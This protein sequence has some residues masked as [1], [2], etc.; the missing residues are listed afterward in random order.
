[1]MPNPRKADALDELVQKFVRNDPKRKAMLDAEL[2]NVQAAELIYSMRTAAG[3]SQRELAKRVR[4]TA[5]VICRL[6]ASDYQGHT[7]AMLNRIADALGQR[8]KLHA[9]PKSAA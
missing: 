9:V 6:E 4:T 3:L 5:T 8:I 1:M 7:L 2:A